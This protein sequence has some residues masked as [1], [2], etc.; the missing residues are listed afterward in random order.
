MI[1]NNPSALRCG[2]A[3]VALAGP[4]VPCLGQTAASALDTRPAFMLIV[5]NTTL[6]TNLVIVTN[7]LVVTNVTYGT[8]FY[9]AQGQLLQPVTAPP[10]PGLVPIPAAAPAPAGPD[11]AVVKAGQTQAV[12]D[13]LASG[14]GAASNKLCVAGSF[15]NDAANTIQI[16]EG[17]TVFDRKKGQALLMA[18]NRAAE[19]AAPEAL[20][21]VQRTVGQLKPENPAQL[22]QSS[23][24]A[25]INFLISTEGQ[26]LAN[27][28]SPLVQREGAAAGLPQA[29]QNV[30]LKGGGL[31][32]AVLGT[33][34]EVDINA[35]VTH[36]LIEAIFRNLAAQE[37][38]IRTDPAARSTKALQDAFKK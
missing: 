27:Q 9:N 4:I 26:S 15:T 14:V 6:K 13:L 3:L 34:K 12:K 16:P 19:K 23:N 24:Y 37:N 8:N 33:S 29:Y 5:T 25:V 18:M 28:I 22:L 35:H 31:F 32:G 30:M 17:V 11:P 20:G 1:M 36:G 7:R 10:I 2:L 38:L 21:V